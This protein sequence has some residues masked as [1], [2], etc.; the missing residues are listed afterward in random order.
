MTEAEEQLSLIYLG[1]FTNK[2]AWTSEQH[3]AGLRAVFAAGAK[4][5]SKSASSSA[6]SST[7]GD[8]A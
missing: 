2:S 3:L 7:T 8:K 5:A 6:S 4:A 1:A